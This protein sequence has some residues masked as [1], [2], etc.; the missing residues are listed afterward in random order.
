MCIFL[1]VMMISF[2][3]VNVQGTFSATEVACYTCSDSTTGKYV[4]GDFSS[5]T[6]CNKMNS[7][8]TKKECLANNCS[9][10]E[11]LDDDGVCVSNDGLVTVLFK[12]GS[13]TVYRSTCTLS[14]GSCRIAL[15]QYQNAIGWSEEPD[16]SDVVENSDEFIT[17]TKAKTYTYYSCNEKSSNGTNKSSSKKSSSKSTVSST[18]SDN[19]PETGSAW[20]VAIFLGGFL[21][22]LYTGY[23]YGKGM[24]ND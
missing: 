10:T 18:T 17:F 5:N 20:I 12:S 14:N 13:L 2:G 6:S 21:M 8:T 1:L 22:I 24:K 3:A 7:Y 19:N 15:R 9:N 16:C 11:T 4:W 23:V